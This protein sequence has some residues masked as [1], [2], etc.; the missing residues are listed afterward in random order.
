MESL[1][2]AK[3]LLFTVD[4]TYKPTRTGE[5]AEIKRLLDNASAN[6]GNG[7]YRRELEHL[8]IHYD[9]L[10]DRSWHGSINAVVFAVLLTLLMFAANK[11]D[12]GGS[13]FEG[14]SPV[15]FGIYFIISGLAYIVSAWYPNFLARGRSTIDDF[16]PFAGESDEAVTRADL[17]RAARKA[18]G[19]DTS[20][21]DGFEAGKIMSK[22]L[23]GV[24]TAFLLPFLAA[25]NFIR[26]WWLK[27]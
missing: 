6:T 21:S 23:F 26:Y 5:M 12:P 25:Y 17:D 24:V 1:K 11:I 16:E 9:R 22:L 3:H 14:I 27:K 2:Q 19:R 18:A 7:D 15:S 20:L 13:D 8:T 4:G 10:A